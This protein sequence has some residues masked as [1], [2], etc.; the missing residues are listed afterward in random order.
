MSET[1][2]GPPFK[3]VFCHSSENFNSVEHIVPESLGND[4][5][6]LEKGWVCDVCNN[7]FSGIENRVLSDSVISVQKVLLGKRNKKGRPGKSNFLGVTLHSV[8]DHERK[9]YVETES[10]EKLFRYGINVNGRNQIR[11]P[12]HSDRCE[13]ISKMLLKIGVELSAVGKHLGEGDFM[14]DPEKAVDFL[15]GKNKIPWPYFMPQDFIDVS[16]KVK[17]AFTDFPDIHEDVSECGFD[18]FFH[19]YYNCKRRSKSVTV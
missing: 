17:S 9:I 16:S 4:C 8:P 18:V 11:I 10:A 12:V 13:D 5:L 2:V 15:L 19:K 3:C 6:V 14:F 1:V 7:L